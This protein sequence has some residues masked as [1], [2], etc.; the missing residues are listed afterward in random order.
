MG[1][2]AVTHTTAVAAQIPAPSD[3]PPLRIAQLNTSDFPQI[4]L[5]LAADS[6]RQ[7]LPAELIDLTLNEN[8]HAVTDFILAREAVGVDLI[9]V[10]DANESINTIDGD[11]DET[12]LKK[13]Q[14]SLI[15]FATQFMD[16]AGL[17]RV[18]V[19][20]PG[21][22]GGSRFLLQDATT[23]TELVN[24]V[25]NY[26][27]QQLT[28]TPLNEMMT[29]ALDHA[30]QLQSEEDERAAHGRFQAII[31]FSDAAQLNQQLDFATL[32]AQAETLNL[33]FYAA[34]LGSRADPDEI[35]NV[36]QL[37]L[38][39]EG[40]YVHLP[41][42]EAADPLFG[43][44]QAQGI[45]ARLTYRTP[46]PQDGRSL[47]TITWGDQ[48][49]A[50]SYTQAV[51]PP[52]AALLL[53][54]GGLLRQGSAADTPLP[55]LTPQEQE[56]PLLVQWPDSVPR[57]LITVSLLVND[58]PQVTLQNPTLDNTSSLMLTWPLAE[59]DTGEYTLMA[60]VTDEFGLTASSEPVLITLIVQRPT[61]PPPTPIPAS[62]AVPPL[63]SLETAV[64]NPTILAAATGSLVLL[65]ALLAWQR[66][67]RKQEI[68]ALEEAMTA[69]LTQTSRKETAV[70]PTTAHLILLDQEADPL[71]L[72]SD[73][74][75]IGRDP[76]VAQLVLDDESVS[77]LH[78][79]I[80]RRDGA[81]WLYDEGSANGTYLEFERLGLA[82]RSLEHGSVIQFGQVRCVF[83]QIMN[84]E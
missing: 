64:A 5:H 48:E 57:G 44:W 83:E 23:P 18:S 53:T 15:R 32:M 12:R 31:L 30:H 46:Q 38:P 65:I 68:L 37:T 8:G 42:K 21:D 6:P 47:I 22:D 50:T 11:D 29:Q 84:N 40:A 4:T 28:A 75:T 51:A 25:V 45:Q 59:L 54:P 55:D 9:F 72:N 67:R 70:G 34:I 69:A 58:T 35:E 81:Y 76:E 26:A 16:P 63:T 49:V 79:R 1:I 20:V 27:P 77:R 10:I 61:P 43:L 14:D 60:Q 82:P 74:I 17:D 66:H 39:S 52:Q 19:L 71:P 56:I 24:G 73:N 2:T 13:V 41:Q 36:T 3:T 7:P 80:R 62:T 33:P 78:A